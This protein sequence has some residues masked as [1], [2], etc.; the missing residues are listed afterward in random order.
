MRSVF[1]VLTFS[2]LFSATAVAQEAGESQ[3]IDPMWLYAQEAMSGI[4]PSFT[5]PVM[6]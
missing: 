2:V 1:T 4:A 6:G 3:S 5:E